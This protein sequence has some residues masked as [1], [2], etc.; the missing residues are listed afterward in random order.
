M[1][2]VSPS[3]LFIGPAKIPTAFNAFFMYCLFQD[4][5]IWS[6]EKY[7]GGVYPKLV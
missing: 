3:V 5:G 2:D 7:L 4:M 6:F 1:N